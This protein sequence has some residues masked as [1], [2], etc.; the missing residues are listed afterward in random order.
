MDKQMPIRVVIA[1]DHA[2]VRRGL[3]HRYSMPKT[4]FDV[5]SRSHRP[6]V[7]PA[8]IPGGIGPMYSCST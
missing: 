1:D 5:V 8:G 3:R 6:R 2:V 7:T 4:D